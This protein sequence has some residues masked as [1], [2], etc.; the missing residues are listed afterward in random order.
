MRTLRDQVISAIDTLECFFFLLQAL[1]DHHRSHIAEFREA[2]SALPKHLLRRLLNDVRRDIGRVRRETKCLISDE[3]VRSWVKSITS[4]G[5][6]YVYLPKWYIDRSLFGNYARVFPRWPHIPLHALV[7]FDTKMASKSPSGLFV[8]EDILFDDV[9]VLWVQVKE[10]VSDGKDFRSRDRS[11][12]R[13]L[14][15]YLR[16]CATGVYPFLEAYINGVAFACFQGF[17][18]ELALA[19]HDFLAEWDSSKRRGRFVSFERKVTDYPAIC[20]RYVNRNV[21]LKDHPSTLFLL[22]EGKLLRDSLTHPSPYI[23]FE[24]G[25]LGKI[26]RLI[27]INTDQVLRLITAACEYVLLVEKALGRDPGQ[28]MPSLKYDF[29]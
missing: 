16:L 20:A 25:D 21:N 6:A 23:N 22:G 3:E 27:T 10:I 19:D 5:D 24:T 11:L 17:H 1:D 7:V 26:A 12:Q 18:S 28:S 14:H 13:R 4:K 9:K 2:S 8:A 15:S 29:L